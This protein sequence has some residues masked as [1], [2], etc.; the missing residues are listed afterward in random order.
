MNYINKLYLGNLNP[1][2]QRFT[3]DSM[4]GK[5]MHQESEIYTELSQLLSDDNKELLKRISELQVQINNIASVDNYAMGFR[6]GSRL[7]IDI[8]LGKNENLNSK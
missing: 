3:N 6:D 4:Y 5:L 1:S 7:I 8:L 2:F